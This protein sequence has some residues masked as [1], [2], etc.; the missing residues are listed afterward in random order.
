MLLNLCVSY[1]Q[2]QHFYQKT[3]SSLLWMMHITHCGHT[4][5]I[6]L[7]E[8]SFNEICW[9]WGLL[10]LRFY[11]SA[12]N[13]TNYILFTYSEKC[14][15]ISGTDI[16]KPGEIN[17]KL[18]AWK[19]ITRYKWE[20]MCILWFVLIYC[21]FKKKKK[22]AHKY[23]SQCCWLSA[24][25]EVSNRQEPHLDPDGETLDWHMDWVQGRKD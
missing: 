17:P 12:V 24:G 13:T 4:G 5:T 22:K 15:E 23:L 18:P 10:F 25:R 1:I 6:S 19:D 9:P 20:N 2:Q 16:T 3:I 14:S 7:L 21:C 8:S 11:I